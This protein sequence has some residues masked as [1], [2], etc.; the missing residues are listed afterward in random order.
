[1]RISFCKRGGLKIRCGKRNGYYKTFNPLLWGFLFARRDIFIDVFDCF[2]C[3]YYFF[4]SS[5][6]RISF[7]KENSIYYKKCRDF[8]ELIAF[9]PLLWGFLFASNKNPILVFPVLYID[10]PEVLSILF[11]EDFFLQE[12]ESWTFRNGYGKFKTFQSSFMRISFCK[13]PSMCLL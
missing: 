7:C 5:F 11:Y 12:L 8:D 13:Y 3:P 9:N 4:Q 2:K 10:K 1:M 6:M